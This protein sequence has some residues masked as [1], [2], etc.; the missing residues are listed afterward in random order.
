MKVETT[1]Y[2]EALRQ[3]T[4]KL[5]MEQGLYISGLEKGVKP[6]NKKSERL[7]SLVPM[8]AKGQFY[9]RPRDLPAQQEFLSYPKGKHD[10]ILD[11]IYYALDGHFP[12]R[13]KRNAFDPDKVIQ[14]RNKVLDWLTM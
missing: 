10:D 7:I 6:R 5:M 8:L 1:G 14:K 3:A 9:F 4:R 12:C 11:A 2:Q 13:V